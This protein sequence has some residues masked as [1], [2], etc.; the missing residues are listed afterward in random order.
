MSEHRCSSTMIDSV[1][2]L[3]AC[4]IAGWLFVLVILRH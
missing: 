2:I 4:L 3:G 1:F